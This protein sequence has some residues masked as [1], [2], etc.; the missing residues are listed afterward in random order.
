MVAL[1][2]R[3]SPAE[4][5]QVYARLLT[6]REDTLGVIFDWSLLKET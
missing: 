2:A 4:A 1:Q 3:H 6:D 5:P